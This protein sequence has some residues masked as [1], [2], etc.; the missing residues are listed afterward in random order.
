MAKKKEEKKNCFII[1]PIGSDNS[2]TRRKTDGIIKAVLE[3]VLSDLSFNCIVAHQITESGSITRQV[4]KHLLEDELVVANLTGLNPNVMYELAVRH[5]KRSPVV[6]IAESGPILP[7]DIATERVIFYENDMA[8]VEELKPRLKKLILNSIDKEE[9]DNPI[10]RVITDQTVLKNIE[11]PDSINEYLLN[12]MDDLFS[13]LDSLSINSSRN[14]PRE[15]RFRIKMNPTG[16]QN[17]S[18]LKGILI[19]LGLVDVLTINETSDR[20][21]LVIRGLSNNAD[22]FN[23]FIKRLSALPEI[24]S[25]DYE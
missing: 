9:P 24:I 6:V 22:D 10:Y 12:R 21:Y 23:Q 15:F 17:K 16:F 11:A 25:I 5:A 2:E 3:P 14:Y 4:I 18:N 7:F 19:K 20:E 8:G 1:T 13:K